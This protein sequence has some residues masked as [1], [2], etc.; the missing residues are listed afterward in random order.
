MRV[1]I[2]RCDF[3]LLSKTIGPIGG[4]LIIVAALYGTFSMARL[5]CLLFLLPPVP[6]LPGLIPLFEWERLRFF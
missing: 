6:A 5:V 2:S 1:Q 4:N 3:L